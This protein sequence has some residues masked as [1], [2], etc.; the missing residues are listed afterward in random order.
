MLFFKFHSEF[1]PVTILVIVFLLLNTTS[2]LFVNN[3]IRFLQRII[4]Q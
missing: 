3:N 1:S 4:A 2:H